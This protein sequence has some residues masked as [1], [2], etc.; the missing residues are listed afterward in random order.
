MGRAPSI[1]F[2][3][4]A[5][6]V[7]GACGNSGNKSSPGGGDSGSGADATEEAGDAGDEG[8]GDGTYPAFTV[9]AP[10]V[11][12]NQGAIIAKPVLVT[13]SWPGDTNA[14]TWEAFGDAIGASTAT[15]RRPPRRTAW[16]RRRAERRTT[17][18]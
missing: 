8:N 9:D 4:A 5:A 1:G 2:L 18:E 7:S 13:V 6:A 15:G 17:C 10:Q 16:P 3:V 11:E 12:K 14:S